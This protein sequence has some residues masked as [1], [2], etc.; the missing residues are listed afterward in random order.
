MLVSKS[1]TG[2]SDQKKPHETPPNQARKRK[3]R[4]KIN[5]DSHKQG[6]HMIRN[7]PC[8]H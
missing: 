8:D 6:I 4:L 5:R 1:N 2:S 7:Y 3:P